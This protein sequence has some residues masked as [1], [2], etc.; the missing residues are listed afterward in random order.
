MRNRFD[1][2]ASGKDRGVRLPSPEP[3]AALSYGKRL[4]RGGF[5]AF[6]LSALTACASFV[7]EVRDYQ[8][9][10]RTAQ[11]LEV[12]TAAEIAPGGLTDCRLTAS[13]EQITSSRFAVLTYRVSGFWHRHVV[14]VDGNPFVARG[15]KVFTNVVRCGTPLEPAVLKQSGADDEKRIKVSLGSLSPIEYR[16]SLG[17]A[18]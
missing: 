12:G 9:G 15:D 8:D 1:A 11:V 7:Q 3:A 18:T 4:G 16:V 13:A 5:Y 6:A 2:V 10:W 17:L 14:I